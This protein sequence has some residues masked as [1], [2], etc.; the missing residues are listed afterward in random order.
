MHP[1]MKQQ[2]GSLTI[3]ALFVIVILSFLGF[4][5]SNQLRTSSQNVVYEVHGTRA[6]L[7][8]Q[9]G[10]ELLAAT[11]FPLNSASAQ[12]NIASPGNTLNVSSVNGLQN[13][14]ITTMCSSQTITENDVNTLVYYQFES[15]GVCQ[16][17]AEWTSRTLARDGV[18]RL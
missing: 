16:A 2:L 5:L 18:V 17:G 7:A 13:C 14:A 12:C 4:A 6:Y 1:N 3:M 9:T 15:T 10:L 8:A 11:S